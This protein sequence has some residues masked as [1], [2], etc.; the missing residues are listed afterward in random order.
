MSYAGSGATAGA[1]VGTAVA[2]GVGTLIGAAVGGLSGFAADTWSSD[3]SREL[4]QENY[5][6]NQL[7]NF[8]YGQE[9]QR[10]AAQNDVSGLLKAGLNPALASGAAPA[11]MVSAPLQNKQAPT[12]NAGMAQ[13][14]SGLRLQEAQIENVEADTSIKE[15]QKDAL[16]IQNQHSRDLDET[17]SEN[18]PRMFREMSQDE[19]YSEAERALFARTA[20]IADEEGVTVGAVDGINKYL[21]L[22]L[23]QQRKL[24]E[25]QSNRLDWNTVIAK[26]EDPNYV[27]ALVRMPETQRQQLLAASAQYMASVALMTQQSET[28]KT[29]REHY[30]AQALEA[31]RKAQAIFH[32]DNAQMAKE[33]DI[34]G[35]MWSIGGSFMETVGKGAVK[36]VSPIKH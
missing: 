20:K 32:G 11:P 1:A 26:V 19:R 13:L 6:K 25:E 17:L 4:D 23:N 30:A 27:K 14:L 18:M 10:N 5:E 12:L 22:R 9:A 36:A 31:T 34:Q 3:R 21:D 2:P 35:L 8:M 7:Q 16:S 15:E 24:V 33:D 29:K 28:E